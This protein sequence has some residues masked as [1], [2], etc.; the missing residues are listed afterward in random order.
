[1]A[2]QELLPS[3]YGM[4]LKINEWKNLVENMAAINSWIPSL[5]SIVLCSDQ[6]DHANQEGAQMCPECHP[7]ELFQRQ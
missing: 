2:K 7:N 1:M 5:S 6:A 4:S 3:K